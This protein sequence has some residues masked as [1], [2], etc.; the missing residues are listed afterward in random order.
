MNG[1]NALSWDE[2]FKLDIWYVEQ[3]SLLIDIKILLLTV[4]SVFK[5]SGISNDGHATMPMFSGTSQ[6]DDE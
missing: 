2:K 6:P 3:Q 5:K 1:R 4:V